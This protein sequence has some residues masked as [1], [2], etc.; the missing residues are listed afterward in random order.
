VGGIH[1]GIPE[2]LEIFIL[3]Q[4]E[5]KSLRRESKVKAVIIFLMDNSEKYT[6]GV[7]KE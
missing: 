2:H 6:G 4:K 3:E 5:P 7:A 1:F